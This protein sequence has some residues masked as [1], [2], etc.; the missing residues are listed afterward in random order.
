[1]QDIALVMILY[2]I[3]CKEKYQIKTQNPL[4]LL[5]FEKT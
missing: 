5:F 2:N 3:N 1:M 4:K